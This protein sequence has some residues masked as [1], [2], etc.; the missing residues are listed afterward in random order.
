MHTQYKFTFDN[1]Y[2]EENNKLTVESQLQTLKSEK[3]LKLSHLNCLSL[4]KN[5]DE[6]R[7][8]VNMGNIDVMTLSETHLNGEIHDSEIQIDSYDIIRKDRNRMGG[9]TVIYI[10]KSI[11]YSIRFDLCEE[12]L[13][14]IAVELK[15]QNVKPIVVVVWYRPPNANAHSFDLF[16]TVLHKLDD[17]QQDFVI[18]GD[19]NCNMQVGYK[20]WQTKRLNDL[21]D[22]FG[23]Y[24]VVTSPTRVSADTSSLVD[25][26]LVNN[27][28]KIGN[29]H[30]IPV[31]LSDHYMISCTWGKQ[32]VCKDHSHKYK[33]NRNIKKVD[34]L[35]YR[36]DISNVQWDCVYNATHVS[37]AYT[38]F[39][40]ALL[41]VI[42]NHAPLKRKRIKKKES[43]WVTDYI[44]QLIRDRNKSKQHAKLTKK[45]DDWKQY[46]KARNNVTAEIRKAKREHITNKIKTSSSQTGDVWQSLSYVMPKKKSSERILE[47]ER[48][49]KR[50]RDRKAIAENFNNY[51]VDVG[52][53]LQKGISC[54]NS[55]NA[56]NVTNRKSRSS[57]ST[58]KEIEEHEAL[59]VIK[60]MSEKKACGDDD[61]PMSLIKPIAH[62][63]VKPL[64]YILNMS[65]KQN[66][67]PEELKVSRITPIFKGGDKIVIGNYRPISTLPV[68]A[69]IF[70]KIIFCQLYDYLSKNYLL[71]N[72]QSGFRPNHSTTT[73]LLKVTEE[74]LDSLDRGNLVGIVTLDLK[75]AFDTVDHCVLLSKLQGLGVNGNALKWIEHYLS[76]RV[77]YTIVNGIRSSKRNIEC[78]VP[79][80]STLGPLLFVVY[81]ND[82]A[83]CLKEC[84]VALYADDTCIY[85][86]HRNAMSVVETLN[87][88]LKAINN[89]L[90]V[91]K[92]VLNTN[93][94]EFLLLGTTKRLK[95]VHDLNVHIESCNIKRVTHLK[96]LGVII[97]ESLNWSKHVEKTS[98]E[99]ISRIYLLKR[100]RPYIT[101]Q[102]ALVYYK[103]IIQGKFDYCDVVW[104]NCAK[105]YLDKLQKLQNRALR[106]VLNV[107]W[108]YPTQLIY[109]QLGIHKLEVRQKH[110]ISHIMY[111]LAHRLYPE[112]L[113]QRFQ[114][115]H[116]SYNFR[117]TLMKF[118]SCKFRT[119]FKRRS[120]QYRGV[121][122]W[123]EIPDEIKIMSFNA[124]KSHINHL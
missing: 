85:T 8:I 61:I 120:L 44:L 76:N 37:T 94:C 28:N 116:S 41:N 53:T 105:T 16:E 109:D 113:C 74:W 46:K 43:P 73:A 47:I 29:V 121:K 3:G 122:E 42:D 64:T 80:G 56:N 12:S 62:L 5:I 102:T 106:T 33:T 45:I 15:M 112:A 48:D 103:S 110:R 30:V 119:N 100:I 111:K 40:K 124:F 57:L 81:I 17:L 59:G 98:K 55:N 96:Y 35:K 108:R 51:F 92:L 27:L 90:K 36:E 9:G 31:S 23:L 89:W 52:K 115:K 69:K 95:N 93:K 86:E 32:K 104:D 54:D 1:F 71:S 25:V 91:N 2:F 22:A 87:K 66:S 26:V 88:E 77:Q 78:G 49:G 63:I 6:I 101:Q 99:V 39:E 75:K 70:E 67:V 79:Q 13:E 114:F 97:D 117:R 84:N 58:F 18:L 118:E 20:S 107:N 4:T 82:L 10:R 19:L 7:E 72:R 50:H 123:N 68:F 65:I 34:M 21:I 14:M 11:N 38:A 24:Q 83:E 60:K